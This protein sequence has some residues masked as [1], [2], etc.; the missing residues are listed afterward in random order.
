MTTQAVAL[1]L[2]TL[3][4]AFSPLVLRF[5]KVDGLTMSAI[6][7]LVAL[8]IAVL[9]SLLTGSLRLD[10]A[11]LVAVLGG[12]TAFWAVQQAVYVFLKR[13]QPSVVGAKALRKTT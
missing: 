7:F 8:L 13:V 2:A 1:T 12:S 3:V 4:A 5:V 6:S 11:S 9:A 10:L